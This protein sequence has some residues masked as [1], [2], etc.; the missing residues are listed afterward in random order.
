MVVTPLFSFS[1]TSPQILKQQAMKALKTT[2]SV[3]EL[4]KTLGLWK[5]RK[6]TDSVIPKLLHLY[7]GMTAYM[8]QEKVYPVDNFYEISIALAFKNA[9]FL[10]EAV[11]RCGSFGIV[12]ERNTYGIKYFYSPLW[13]EKF[14]SEELPEK[15]PETFPTRIIYIIYILK[16]ILL[17]KNSR[18]K[19]I[20]L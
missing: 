15:F 12:P 6:I 20:N 7:L 10:T 17:T 16:G 3:T 1:I 18:R 11:K 4:Q 13:I 9:K 19:A 14:S 8:N 5:S 2:I